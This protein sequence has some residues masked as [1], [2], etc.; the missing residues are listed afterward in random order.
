MQG[1]L[2]T[3]IVDCRDSSQWPWLCSDTGN[4]VWNQFEGGAET[5]AKFSYEIAE[6]MIK[7]S[8][9]LKQKKG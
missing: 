5:L 3:T 2:A 4:L 1:L 9:E 8:N 6:A 7:R